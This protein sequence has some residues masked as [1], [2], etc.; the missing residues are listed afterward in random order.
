MPKK[1]TELPLEEIYSPPVNEPTWSTQ[2]DTEEP[3]IDNKFDWTD[4][5]RKK[6]D[7][8]RE[9]HAKYFSP[10]SAY[11]ELIAE[12]QEQEV[13]EKKK[14]IEKPVTKEDVAKE[15]Q[16]VRLRER[17]KILEKRRKQKEKQDKKK[18]IK[19]HGGKMDK[20]PV[21]MKNSRITDHAKEKQI[22]QQR[23][24][25][26]QE[27]IIEKEEDVPAFK[28]MPKQEY[29]KEQKTRRKKIAAIPG[30]TI[31]HCPWCNHKR[32]SLADIIKHVHQIHNKELKE[33][34]NETEKVHVQPPTENNEIE[35]NRTE[36]KMLQIDIICSLDDDG[37]NHAKLEFNKSIINSNDQVENSIKQKCFQ[38]KEAKMDPYKDDDNRAHSEQNLQLHDINRNIS[39]SE[40]N[41]DISH[42]S[43]S[44][45][46]QQIGP[47]SNIDDSNLKDRISVDIQKHEGKKLSVTG[48][49]VQMLSPSLAQSA[50]KQRSNSE[51]E[52][53][54]TGVTK[55]AESNFDYDNSDDITSQRT[56]Q[57]GPYSKNINLEISTLSEYNSIETKETMLKVGLEKNKPSVKRDPVLMMPP[58]AARSK[59]KVSWVQNIATK[60]QNFY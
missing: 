54:S 24:E 55:D 33:H 37:N 9:K 32:R 41:D 40:F 31:V 35:G 27:D 20:I 16:R 58:N 12:P 21:Y 52:G 5:T 53:S 29:Q 28:N 38:N 49:S 1:I 19:A 11:C 26:H 48:K 13:R 4:Q 6:E 36:K 51:Q 25:S 14:V 3:N 2:E 45:R 39:I 50:P 60:V 8:A 15:W 42:V 59:I 47:F 46:N 23:I 22:N 34:L 43:S 10:L 56:A 44:P 17:E 7:K 30:Q 57:I 18:T